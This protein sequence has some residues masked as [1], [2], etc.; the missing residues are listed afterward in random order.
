M[1]DILRARIVVDERVYDNEFADVKT[2]AGKRPVSYDK[3]GVILGAIRAMWARNK[4]LRKPDDLVF[5]ERVGKKLDRHNLLHR[6]LKPVG[7]SV[8][9]E[10]TIDFR[11][12]RTTHAR[13]MPRF[14]A[15]PEVAGDNMGHSGSSGSIRSMCIQRRDGASALKPHPRSL[16]PCSQN[17]TGK[18]GKEPRFR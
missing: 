11:C 1:E 16:K 17:R 3:H 6:H 5:A 10:K 18:E 12:F 7:E 4:G 2:D 15:R 14:G 13:L 8:S 9:L